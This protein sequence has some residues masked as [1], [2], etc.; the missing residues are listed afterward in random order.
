[1]SSTTSDSITN[2]GKQNSSSRNF[3]FIR[4]SL[5]KVYEYDADIHIISTFNPTECHFGEQKFYSSRQS[6]PFLVGLDHIC[7]GAT[8]SK[9]DNSTADNNEFIVER[10]KRD[11]QLRLVRLLNGGDFKKQ[12]GR[13]N[14]FSNRKTFGANSCRRGFV[15][16]SLDSYDYVCVTEQRQKF[17]QRENLLQENRISYN[18]HGIKCIEPF[19]PRRAFPGD[20]ICVLAEEK[21]HI[22]RENSQA[23]FYQHCIFNFLFRHIVRCFMLIS[24]MGLIQSVHNH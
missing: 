10:S 23:C 7:L 13:Q 9:N 12:F 19:L 1:M 11:E 5:K 24:S 6:H 3:Q 18:G 16:R 14:F 20:E 21:F 22:F 2:K 17:A 8:M 15:W 4:V